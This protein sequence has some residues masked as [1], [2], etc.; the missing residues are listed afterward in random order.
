[1]ARKSRKRLFGEEPEKKENNSAAKKDKERIYNV[2]AY[3]RL[4]VITDNNAESL[5]NQIELIKEFTEQRSDLKITEIYTD[6]GETGVLFERPGFERMMKD[7]RNGKIDCIIVKDL[8][9]FGRNFI[10]TGNYI[11]KIFPY[12]N[13]RFISISDKFDSI[14]S[15][16]DELIIAF[17]N[18]ANE[19]YARDISKKT[20]AALKSKQIDGKYFNSHPPY[21]YI[22]DQNDKYKLIP[23][24]E[25]APIIKRIFEMR[26][27]GILIADIASRLNNENI[28]TPSDYFK[29][30]NNKKISERKWS[31]SVIKSLLLNHIYIGTYI[32]GKRKKEF[33]FSHKAITTDKSE[34]IIN[35]N[36]CEALVDKETFEKVQKMFNKITSQGKKKKVKKENI[37]SGKIFCKEC[38]IELSV[39]FTKKCEQRY[40][41]KNHRYYGNTVCK[42]KKTIYA[43]YLKKVV[44]SFMLNIFNLNY[45]KYLFSNKFNKLTADE[46]EDIKVGFENEIKC[47]NEKKRILFEEYS[48][49]FISQNDFLFENEKMNTKK[50]NLERK[51]NDMENFGYNDRSMNN[52]VNLIRNFSQDD[53]NRLLLNVFIKK[54]NIDKDGSIEIIPNFSNFFDGGI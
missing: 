8:S 19:F 40:F 52:K 51:L 50:K 32:A 42:N 38:G 54:I 14:S 20:R 39:I 7:V 41:C 15:N 4:S 29:S 30:I 23:N 21:G 45:S 11:E 47:I 48:N 9:R 28:L 46:I 27:D 53:V 22:K 24:P 34:W 36:V 44:Y 18:F 25:T 6:Y 13:I 43:K 31:Y 16:N 49:A 3:A 1:M 17:K 26:A 10:E 5:E 2:A 37:F 12:L 33:I 35:E